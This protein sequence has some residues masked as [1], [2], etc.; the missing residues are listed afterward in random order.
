MMVLYDGVSPFGF[1]VSIL[2]VLISFVP[3]E[4][5]HRSSARSMSCYARYKAWPPG[6]IIAILSSFIGIVLA[7]PGHVE[8]SSKYY[9]RWGRVKKNLTVKQIGMT[10]LSGPMV[11]LALGVFFLSLPWRIFLGGQNIFMVGSY[12]NILLALFNLFPVGSL[13]GK[14]ILTWNTGIWAF[15]FSTSAIFY[16]LFL[17]A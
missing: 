2:F 8:I 4:L 12:I 15:M 13:D 16:L 3:H 11:N 9:E 1:L 17:L 7:A 14:K 6:L 10:S 5:A